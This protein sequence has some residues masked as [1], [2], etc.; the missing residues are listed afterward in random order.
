MARINVSRD[1]AL[2]DRA[3]RPKGRKRTI[4]VLISCDEV[5]DDAISSQ[6]RRSPTGSERAQAVI[7]YHGNPAKR[8]NAPRTSL[9][10]MTPCRY[11]FPPFS[12]PRP[13]CSDRPPNV[14]MRSRRSTNTI[15]PSLAHTSSVLPPHHTIFRSPALKMP[16]API[17]GKVS[18]SFASRVA[19]VPVR[20][21][22]FDRTRLT[23][24]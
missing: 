19:W 2:V 5:D 11:P 23:T 6:P 13:L 12:C 3:M 1:R 15:Y 17:V 24:S 10:S 4:R 21:T 8:F 14:P 9:T 16:L 20:P 22:L 18:C 7:T